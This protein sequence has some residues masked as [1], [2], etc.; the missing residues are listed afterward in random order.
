MAKERIHDLKQTSASFQIRGVV[1]G[2]KKNNA[3]QSGT[4]KNGGNWNSIEFGL[5]IN[6]KKPVFIKLNGFPRDEVYYY[7]AAEKKGE[8]GTTKKVAW[9]DRKKSPGEGFRLIGVNISTDKDENG[10]NINEMFVEYDAV[11]YLH[12]NLKDGDSLFVKGNMV[13][14]SYTDRNDQPQRK[15]ELVPTQI[16]YT[17]DAIDFSADD[18]KEMAE[19]ENTLV[20]SDIEKETDENGKSTGRF[21]LT[22]YSIGYSTVEP[23][24]FIIDQDHAKLAGNIKK[25]LK[26]SN[27]IKTYGRI[28]IVSNVSAVDDNDDDDGWG[29]SS[30]M[31][32]QNAPVKR[33]Y[34]IYKAVPDSIDTETYSEDSIAKA[35]KAIKN[36][37]NAEEKFADKSDDGNEDWGKDD[38]NHDEDP[39]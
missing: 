25:K 14:S 28:E 26:A 34:I 12:D 3:Y 5:N 24:S 6:D 20:F 15:V 18:F 4:S 38:D 23:V 10:K 16:S 36:A 30:P 7:K 37:K 11:E 27:S 35:I 31:E 13:F 29:E 2:M 39:W 33:E 21:I 1:F 17:Q 9:K 19:F 22:G 32:R 8:K